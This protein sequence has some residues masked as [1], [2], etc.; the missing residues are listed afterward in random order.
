MRV[1]VHVSMWAN[2][3][4]SDV[5]L[6]LTG[7]VFRRDRIGRR[8]GGVIFCIKYSVQAYKLEGD[9]NCGEVV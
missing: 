3:Y 1:C 6:R 7:Y 4:I 8:G 9:A 5:E 2:K